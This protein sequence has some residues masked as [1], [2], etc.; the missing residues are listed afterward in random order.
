[1]EL[2]HHHHHL[3]EYLTLT[4]AGE[5]QHLLVFLILFLSRDLCRRK[6]VVVSTIQCHHSGFHPMHVRKLL[7]ERLLFM[8][9]VRPTLRLLAIL[10]Y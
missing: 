3:N 10:N 6:H 8:F 9:G 1:M 5:N 2:V 4:V 7:G